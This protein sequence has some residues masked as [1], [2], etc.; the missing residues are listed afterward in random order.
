MSLHILSWFILTLCPALAACAEPVLKIA[1]LDTKGVPSE[2]TVQEEG[3]KETMTFKS[4]PQDSRKAMD[5]LFKYLAEDL[6]K[7]KTA[8]EPV[9]KIEFEFADTVQYVYV[10]KMLDESKQA[11][12]EKVSPGSMGKKPVG[13]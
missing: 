6:K 9:P 4:T 11:G 5:D 3:K 12:F 1:I 8:K 13:K 7:R 10:M 2:I